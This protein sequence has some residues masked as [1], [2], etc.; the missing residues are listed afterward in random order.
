MGLVVVSPS[1]T[2][3]RRHIGSRGHRLFRSRNPMTLHS[4]DPALLESLATANRLVYDLGV[5]D[6]LVRRRC[7]A[8]KAH[9]VGADPLR[10]AGQIDPYQ[11]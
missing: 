3:M 2:V 6:D 10:T 1:V 11:G 8:I 5:L 9:H 4:A 7:R